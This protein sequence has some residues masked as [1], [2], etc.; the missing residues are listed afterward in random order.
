M[1]QLVELLLDALYQII[2]PIFLIL[3][4]G[5][6]VGRKLFLARPADEPDQ[7]LGHVSHQ[8]HVVPASQ[9]ETGRTNS[10]LRT[11]SS[12]VFYVFTPCLAFSSLASSDVGVEEVGRIGLF[13]VVTT[14]IIGGIAWAL[15]CLLHLSPPDT[16][17]LL[18]VA[19]FGNVGNYGLPFNELAFGQ[20]GSERAVIYMIVSS[21]LVFSLGI[22]VAARVQGSAPSQMLSKM[23]H[24]PIV[25]ALL[26]AGLAR[27]GVLPVPDPIQKAVAIVAQGTVP[28]MLL[29]L[30]MQ[31]SEVHIHGKWRL[32]SLASGVRLLLAPLIALPLAG[33]LGLTGLPAQVSIIEASMPSAV[34]AIILSIEFDLALDLT[35]GV[36]FLTTLLSPVTLILLVSYLR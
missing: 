34:Y 13:V 11:L 22:L 23:A 4:G 14:T 9:S 12:L 25:Y 36:V 1:S 18:L 19:M 30:G 3:G 31:L 6:V 8:R 32:I 28:L 26:L 17:S 33:L 20:R 16:S 29:I 10:S 21:V 15:A 24:L 5:F 35:T 2:L 27:L 7:P